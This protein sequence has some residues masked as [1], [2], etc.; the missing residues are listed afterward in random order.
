M[1]GRPHLFAVAAVALAAGCG[2]CQDGSATVP[3]LVTRADTPG[4]DTPV[5]AGPAI[6]GRTDFAVAASREGGLAY[7][8]RDEAGEVR[9]HGQ[10]GHGWVD[11]AVV[12][13][14][15]AGPLGLSHRLTGEA[16]VVATVAPV[17]GEAPAVAAHADAP[18]AAAAGEGDV[19]LAERRA[20]GHWRTRRIAA[21]AL[22]PQVVAGAGEEVHLVF[23]QPAEA[24]YAVIYARTDGIVTVREEVGQ[25]PHRVMPHLVLV[26]DA[27][28]VTFVGASGVSAPDVVEA[29]VVEAG[30]AASDTAAADVAGPG[31]PVVLQ[32]RADAEGAFG[33]PT[34]LSAGV[35]GRPQAVP[36]AVA[37]RPDAGGGWLAVIRPVDEE[38]LA[39]DGQHELALDRRARSALL[40]ARVEGDGPPSVRLLATAGE[41][42][43]SMIAM[44][45]AGPMRTDAEARTDAVA[46]SDAETPS[47][48]EAPDELETSPDAKAPTD[49]EARAEAEASPDRPAIAAVLGGVPALLVPGEA[50]RVEAPGRA[51]AAG[52]SPT[53]ALFASDRRMWVVPLSAAP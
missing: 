12:K 38:G 3:H 2:G 1:R 10:S 23:L 37:W 5:R 47:D 14:A 53:S 6:D 13:D 36:Q 11:E 39:L 52:L 49:G 40:L 48:A 7:A 9:Y 26:E 8:A 20:P 45:R 34:A 51:L 35:F 19:V 44:S 22:M 24:R 15:L 27:P 41:G 50:P 31:G 32:A 29:A 30:M 21:R 42:G 18:E 4:I 33:P 46:P 28:L 16:V 25:T 17:D 43:A